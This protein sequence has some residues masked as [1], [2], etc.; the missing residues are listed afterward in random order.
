MALTAREQQIIESI[1]R[2]LVFS[3][4]LWAVRFDRLKHPAGYRTRRRLRLA[5]TLLVW[6]AL[7]CLDAVRSPG[8]WLWAALTASAAAL[9]L[10]GIRRR[11]ARY[12][13]ALRRR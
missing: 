3:S 1:E 10:L 7:V 12:G 8:P 6:I 4:P 13:H 11:I 5:A 2:Q 9:A